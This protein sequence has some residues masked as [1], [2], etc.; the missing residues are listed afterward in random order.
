M[1]LIDALYINV[2]GG[3][4]LLNYLISELEKTDYPVHYLLD[5]RI[6]EQHPKV[7]KSN[8]VLCLVAG[9]KSRKQFY[10]LN[11]N[12]FSKVLCFGNIPPHIL[13]SII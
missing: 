5:E 13:T 11:K 10:K 6:R 12:A 3:K 9:I 4:V 1:L 2:G 7:K 8:Q